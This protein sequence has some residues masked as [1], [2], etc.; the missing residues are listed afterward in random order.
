MPSYS[1]SDLSGK[2]EEILAEALRGPVTITQ[3]DKPPLV[4]LNIEDYARLL[5]RAGDARKVFRSGEE[6]AQVRDELLAALNAAIDR[7][8]QDGE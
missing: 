8:P 1:T 4:L 5:Q 7:T 2:S 3:P 6:P